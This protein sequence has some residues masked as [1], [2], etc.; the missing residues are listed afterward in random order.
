MA[1]M[2][3]RAIGVL[4]RQ[5]T[6]LL[7]AVV[8][9]QKSAHDT[10]FFRSNACQEHCD[11]W[12]MHQLQSGYEGKRQLATVS[13]RFNSYRNIKI[14]CARC[15]C[16]L[17]RY[18]KRNGT[19]S[20]LI[21]ILINRIAEDPNNMIPEYF[22]ELPSPCQCPRCGEA[23]ARPVVIKGSECALKIIGKRVRIKG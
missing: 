22:D 23:F 15:N 7:R 13:R 5:S 14:L 2:R 11:F 17:F 19:K 20:A 4:L 6:T 10:S 16:M 3:G 18:K 21:K 8:T 9:A 12:S 1:I